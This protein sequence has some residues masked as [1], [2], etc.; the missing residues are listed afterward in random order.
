[1]DAEESRNASA[2]A[3]VSACALGSNRA[4][5]AC[6][7]HSGFPRA[8]ASEPES[9]LQQLLRTRSTTVGGRAGVLSA[10]R[11]AGHKI[12]SGH[13]M[14]YGATFWLADRTGLSHETGVVALQGLLTVLSGVLVAALALQCY[15]A[16]VALLACFLWSTYPFH[17]WLTKQPSGETLVSVLRGR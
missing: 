3:A 17:L 6:G 10:V 9:G 5:V 1:M 15:G 12:S 2:A 14:V 13:T 8:A 4:H 11:R 16:R 7:L